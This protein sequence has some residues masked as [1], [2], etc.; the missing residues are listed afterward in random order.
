[1]EARKRT[2]GK[3]QHGDNRLTWYLGRCQSHGTMCVRS[4]TADG[5]LRA[6]HRRYPE[7]VLVAS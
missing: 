6:G 3:A 4:T 7:Q 1:M 5:C 2:V